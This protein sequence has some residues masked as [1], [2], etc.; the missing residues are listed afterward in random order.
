MV[1]NNLDFATCTEVFGDPPDSIGAALLDHL[2]RCCR[3]IEF[4][5]DSFRVKESLRRQERAT[6]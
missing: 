6:L 3:I 4:K 1:T 5:G 2:T